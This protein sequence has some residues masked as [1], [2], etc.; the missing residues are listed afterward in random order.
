[1]PRARRCA[2]D[3]CTAALFRGKRAGACKSAGLAYRVVGCPALCCIQ[4]GGAVGC[5]C[6][7]V[8]AVLRAGAGVPVL[9]EE[10][11]DGEC[12]LCAPVFGVLGLHLLP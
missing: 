2:A 5:L 1:M 6:S 12:G 10:L 7:P 9:G 3:G 8:G 4:L 11:G